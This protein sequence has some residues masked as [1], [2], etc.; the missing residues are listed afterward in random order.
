MASSPRI[1]IPSRIA[2]ASGTDNGAGEGACQ[3]AGKPA[4]SSSSAVIHRGL[5]W[6]QTIAAWP[7]LTV[8]IICGL[9][10]ALVVVIDVWTGTEV[11]VPLLYFVPIIIAS[12]R[13]ET[14][15]GLIVAL[16]SAILARIAY[17]QAID[18]P[19]GSLAL[20]ANTL[21][22]VGIYS[23][24]A[25]VTGLLQRQGQ[26]LQRQQQELEQAQRRMRADLR[27]A[28]LLPQH[29]LRRPVP[30]VPGLE[31]AVEIRFA[32]AVGGDFYDLRLVDPAA[33]AP[34]AVLSPRAA[35]RSGSRRPGAPSERGAHLAI[36]VADV[37]GK[38]AKAALISAAL[39]SLLDETSDRPMEPGAFLQHLNTRF[40]EAL[41]DEMFVTMFYGHLDLESG[42]LRYASAGHDP[43]FLC[44]EEGVEC[45]P[46]TAAALGV[47]PE[48]PA[49]MERRRLRPHETL[50]LYTDGLTTA[51]DP[52]GERLTEERVVAW[53]QERIA[54]P[55]AEL[56]AGLL[57]LAC[58]DTG[59]RPADDITLVALRRAS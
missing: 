12:L 47:L 10:L 1:S 39:R 56:I 50:L 2:G 8:A 29:L 27:A 23:L 53:L 37:S 31:A 42:E 43:P 19:V 30:E 20:V 32:R 54:A 58:A 5:S 44:G 26:R 57:G 46:P 16:A 13:F 18:R 48:L 25:V 7:A 22:E 14:L 3:K 40:Y 55:P 9:L 49:D 4:L 21:M 41:P 28:E 36:C 38:G 51:L 15:G 34:E 59:A 11:Q 17:V 24:V 33:A 45:L 52:W 35:A 6:M